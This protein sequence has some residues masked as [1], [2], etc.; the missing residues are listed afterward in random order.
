MGSFVVPDNIATLLMVFAGSSV[1]S[2]AVVTATEILSGAI[3]AYVTDISFGP[4]VH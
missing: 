3:C 1:P 4:I 2:G